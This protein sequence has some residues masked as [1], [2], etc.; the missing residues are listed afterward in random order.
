MLFDFVGP[1]TFAA[2]GPR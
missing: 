2:V 1:A